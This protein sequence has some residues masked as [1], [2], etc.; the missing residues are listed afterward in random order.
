MHRLGLR[1]S[2]NRLTK[3]EQL[4]GRCLLALD[5]VQ[6]A[7]GLDFP[8]YVTQAPGETNLLHVV[9]SITGTGDQGRISTLDL[10]TSATN[11]FLTI[12]YT[13]PFAGAIRG[14]DPHRHLAFVQHERGESV[15]AS[16]SRKT[17][18]SSQE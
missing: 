4:E 12:N 7:S 16:Q 8:S 14:L 15:L 5:I 2:Q 9:E 17:R 6:V 11:P 3:F 10:D 13:T 1:G 18:P